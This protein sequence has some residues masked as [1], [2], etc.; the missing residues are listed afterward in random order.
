MSRLNRRTLL[1]SLAAGS[2]CG[3]FFREA[4]PQSPQSPQPKWSDEIARLILAYLESL[5]RP[6]GG[7]GWE[8]QPDSHLTPTVA[9]VVCYKHLGREVPNK[10]TVAQFIRTHHP[11]TGENAE[12][13]RHAAELRSLVF[14]Q[15]IGLQALSED[16]SDFHAQVRSWTKPS[17]YPEMYEPRR[18]PL[19]QQETLAVIGRRVLGLPV[20]DISP[21][22]IA[23]FDSRRRPNGSFNNTPADDGTDGHVTNTYRGLLTL[24]ALGRLDEKKQETTQWLRACQLPNGAFTWQPNAQIGGIDDVAYTADALASLRLLDAVPADRAK[25]LD[26][27][28]SLWNADGGFGDRPGLPSS[29]SATARALE[30]FMA[31]GE[32]PRGPRRPAIIPKR[33]PSGLKPF[34]IQIEAQGN[35]SPIEAVELARAL[36]IHLWGAKN[37]APGWIERAQAVANERKVPVLFFVSN[38]EYGTFV[39]VPGLG[40]YSHTS[41]PIWPAGADPG[42]SYANKGPVPWPEFRDKRIAAIEKVGGRMTWQINDN[43]EWSR[44]QIDDG[45]ERGCGYSAIATF[46]HSQNFAYMLPFLFRYRHLIPFISLQDAHGNEAWWWADELTGYRTIFLATGPTWDGWLKALKENWVVAVRHDFLTRY[47]TRLLG[48]APG[49]Q[50]FVREREAEWKWWGE[51][52]ED[53][54]RPWASVV[55]LTPRDE[56][57]VGRPEQGIAIR[58]RCWWEG[59][60]QRQKPIVELVS[61]T[62]DGQAVTP[63]LVQRHGTAA[64]KKGTKSAKAAK[65][66]GPLVDVYYIHRIAA[67]SHGKHVAIAVV[68][69][70]ET[71]QQREVRVEFSV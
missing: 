14:E 2:L 23:Y 66:D 51:N 57:E 70:I 26:Y 29:P 22:L 19:F 47:R 6:D 59:R 24:N 44:V 39:E 32:R 27:L 13:G 71:N 18:Y 37:S 17:L 55:A 11:I 48:G 62:V 4:A 35:G 65:A 58:V 33:L 43:E 31:L 56:F 30:A 7:Y 25:C 69:K 67:P 46:H 12:A 50:D 10:K 20:N 45:L 42:P 53:L 16:T 28:C 36:R 3:A 52:P 60:M 9:V 21:E 54:Q 5:A 8:D 63:E 41:D 40:I 34:T 15:I 64:A 68:R 38:E 49:V 61:L 1:H